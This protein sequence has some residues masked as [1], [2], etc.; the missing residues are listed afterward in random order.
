MK[1]I[2]RIIG[3]SW[4]LCKKNRKGDRKEKGDGVGK[5]RK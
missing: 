4:T 3:T 1:E 5:T 2:F